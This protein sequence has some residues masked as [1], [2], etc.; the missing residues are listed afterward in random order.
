[1]QCFKA[2]RANKLNCAC[3]VFSHIGNQPKDILRRNLKT[4]APVLKNPI[5]VGQ[6]SP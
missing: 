5:V 2:L 3:A 6:Q 1:L 4:P